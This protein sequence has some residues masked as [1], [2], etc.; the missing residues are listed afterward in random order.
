MPLDLEEEVYM[1]QP[2]G[3][4][5]KGESELVCCLKS[6]YGLKQSPRAWLGRFSEIVIEFGLTRCGVDHFVFYRQTKAGKI[7]LIVYMDDIVITGDDSEGIRELKSYLK[8]K[9]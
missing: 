6:L 3:S 1:E 8:T 4:I 2:P 9:F 5:A 7:L